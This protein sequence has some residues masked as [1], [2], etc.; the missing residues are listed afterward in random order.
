MILVSG[1]I[2]VTAGKRELFLEA[3]RDAMIKA[4]ANHDC[5]EFIVAADPL[6]PD[7]VNIHEEWVSEHALEAFRGE[8]PDDDIAQ[9]IERA[10]VTQHTVTLGVT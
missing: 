5:L 3:S 10:E 9:Y 2:F 6:E 7:R 8:G 4:R 1:R